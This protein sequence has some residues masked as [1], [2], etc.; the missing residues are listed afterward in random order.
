M[1]ELDLMRF[2][3]KVSQLQQLV[4]SLAREPYRR[5]QLAECSNHNQVVL[6]ARS[7]GYEIGRRWGES[8]ASNR[9]AEN[10]LCAPTPQAGEEMERV[11]H[12]GNGWR[13]VLIASNQARCPEGTWMDQ[14]EH[15]WVM[16]LKGSARL[17]LAD[18]DRLIDL[19][20]GDHLHLPPRC[21]HRVERT[22][23]EPGTLWLALHWLDSGSPGSIA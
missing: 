21:R 10:L 12:S 6:L 19:S 14:A 2:L 8:D 4:D 15:E 22:D 11:L 20:A 3:D 9:M 16:V 1:A 7:W 17:R 13:L 5:E 18:P 23:P